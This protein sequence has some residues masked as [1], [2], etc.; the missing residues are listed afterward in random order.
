MTEKVIKK[1]HVEHNVKWRSYDNSFN[2]WIDNK[3]IV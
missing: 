2:S 1:Y 3:Y